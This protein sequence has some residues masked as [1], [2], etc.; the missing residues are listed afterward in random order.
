MDAR[1]YHGGI[2]RTRLHP[3]TFTRL[4]RNGT[5]VIV[6]MLACVIATNFIPW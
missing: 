4:D 3:L 1:C 2:G 6:A 5:L